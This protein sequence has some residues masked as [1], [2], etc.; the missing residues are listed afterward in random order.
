MDTVQ[1]TFR[2]GRLELMQPVDWPEGTRA[3][4]IP[5]TATPSAAEGDPLGAWPSDYFENTAGALV[6]EEFE[7]PA[8][9][10]PTER[11]AW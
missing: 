11:D 2:N 8:Q 1:A 4:V 5:L 9:G 10:I 3:N 6:G 7:R